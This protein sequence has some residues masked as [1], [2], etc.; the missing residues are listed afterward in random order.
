[1]SKIRSN[2]YLGGIVEVG[3]EV[4]LRENGITRCL[5]V[6]KE[7]RAKEYA[8]K[9]KDKS[10]AEIKR[11]IIPLIDR[12]YAPLLQYL[13]ESVKCL[14]RWDQ[15]GE[16]IAIHCAAGI[17]RSSS[18]VIAYLMVSERLSYA[19]ALA[20]VKEKRPLINPNKG[21]QLQLQYFETVQPNFDPLVDQAYLALL[22]KLK[23]E[24]KS[25][26]KTR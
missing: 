12:P 10:A 24:F 21:F 5:T 7:F 1:M 22:A 15:K 9:K 3:E 20:E 8:I 18:I 17:S 11:K 2:I 19:Q 25:T 14:Q 4:F 26:S 23:A 6:A 16:K 13:A